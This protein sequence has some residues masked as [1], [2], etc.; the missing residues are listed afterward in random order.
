MTQ[1]IRMVPRPVD[2]LSDDQLA[3][4]INFGRARAEVI[5]GI[6]AAVRRGDRDALWALGETLVRMRDE[7]AKVTEG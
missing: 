4:V 7:A 1:P 6:E 5:A 3:R 2:Q